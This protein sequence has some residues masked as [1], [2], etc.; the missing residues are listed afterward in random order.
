MIAVDQV[1][2]SL[3]A[4]MTR[5][6]LVGAAVLTAANM[7]GAAETLGLPA[8]SFPP[9][10][11]SAA[12]ETQSKITLETT[13]PPEPGYRGTITGALA[14]P[15]INGEAIRLSGAVSYKAAEA[16]T[17]V[18]RIVWTHQVGRTGVL[19][20]TM[21]SRARVQRGR[22]IAAG[23]ALTIVGDLDALRN[24]AQGFAVS[25]EQK[26]RGGCP[27]LVHYTRG[28]VVAQTRNISL[29]E[30]GR[31]RYTDCSP[32]V[33]AGLWRIERDYRGCDWQ[34]GEQDKIFPAYRLVYRPA[35][36]AG[37]LVQIQSC[38]PDNQMPGT[39]FGMTIG[40][41]TQVPHLPGEGAGTGFS[42]AAQRYGWTTPD[43]VFRGLTP[44]LDPI[45]VTL[46]HQVRTCKSTNNLGV[47]MSEIWVQT[48]ADS[49]THRKL[50]P[51]GPWSLPPSAVDKDASE[52]AGKFY[53]DLVGGVSYPTVRYTVRTGTG[54][55][56][57]MDVLT[58]ISGCLPD[59]TQI[60][61]HDERQIGWHHADGVLASFPIMQRIRA[62]TDLGPPHI[63][64]PSQPYQLELEQVVAAGVAETVGCMTFQ[65]RQKLQRYRRHDGSVI[66]IYGLHEPPNVIDNCGR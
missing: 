12:L 10:S 23:T 26:V 17:V 59:P 64:D 52:C 24:G 6:A 30:G 54:G 35:G 33:A 11:G 37:P 28:V 25:T 22:A 36:D 60:I 61:R 3:R 50:L 2:R 31:T 39:P 13:L 21:I 29:P 51:C 18:V 58:P 20:S 62:N 16:D 49:K 63:G 44:C 46:T 43:G 1:L 34:P 5:A 9:L 41:C 27:D 53:D 15:A 14:G 4:L 32:D 48:D 19:N 40:G 38:L 56:Q 55:E 65:A 47:P 8:D 66:D 42:V 57:A 45:P 7:A